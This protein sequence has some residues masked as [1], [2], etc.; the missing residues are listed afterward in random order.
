MTKTPWLHIQDHRVESTLGV[1]LTLE[2]SQKDQWCFTSI[3]KTQF[4]ILVSMNVIMG[5]LGGEW[6]NQSSNE[7][8]KEAYLEWKRTRAVLVESRV[9]GQWQYSEKKAWNFKNLDTQQPT[10][11]PT[12][13]RTS[14]V[15]WTRIKIKWKRFQYSFTKAHFNRLNKIMPFNTGAL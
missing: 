5:W 6:I 7:L 4:R 2:Q 1:S 10:D 12:K 9:E 8:I 15:H 3:I 13:K 14:D 11:E